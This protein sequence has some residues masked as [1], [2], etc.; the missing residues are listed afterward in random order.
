M[1][2]ECVCGVGVLQRG[3]G[4]SAGPAAAAAGE[5]VLVGTAARVGGVL[6]FLDEKWKAKKS[7]IIFKASRKS[8]VVVEVELIV[9][10]YTTA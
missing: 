2:D 3:E 7:Y 9:G 5:G 6:H 4:Q 8:F 1:D 10:R